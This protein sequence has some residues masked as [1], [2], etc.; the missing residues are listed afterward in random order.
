M[1]I[2]AK[3]DDFEG[4]SRFTTW[5]YKFVIFEVSNKLA[6]HA[7]RH[8]PPSA[9]ELTFE[10]LPDTLAARPGEQAERREQLPC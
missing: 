3:L 5:A 1:N 9:D 8:H 4:R 10:Q 2:L 6:R 7:W